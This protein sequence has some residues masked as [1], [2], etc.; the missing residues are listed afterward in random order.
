M[1][2]SS[3]PDK[4]EPNLEANELVSLACE[5]DELFR[6]QQESTALNKADRELSQEEQEQLEF[7]KRA[8]RLLRRARN[9]LNSSIDVGP[10]GSSTS[11]TGPQG[12]LT[13]TGNSTVT[14]G[15]SS[16]GAGQNPTFQMLG[17]FEVQNEI[18]QGGFSRVFRARDPQLDRLVALKVPKPGVLVDQTTR[19]RFE[20]EAHAAAILSHPNIVPT[21]EVGSAGP[22]S[23][24]AMGYCEGKTLAT[25]MADRKLDARESAE[26]ISTLAMAVEHAHQRGIVHRDLKPSNVLI[27]KSPSR[28]STDGN[29]LALSDRLRISDFGLAKFESQDAT[30]T[31]EGAIVGTPAYMSPEQ[32][33]GKV[34]GA[35]T[36]IYALGMILCELLTG[37]LP[38]L[39][40][41][42]LATLRAVE[43]YPVPNI[44]KLNPQIPKDLAAIAE[45]CL[46]KNPNERYGSAFELAEE[47]QNWLNGRPVVA[48][49]I[50]PVEQFSK[51]CRRNPAVAASLTA[52]MACLTIGLG[53]A[54]WN[55][56][57][58]EE[59]RND[60]LLFSD[61][62]VNDVL[63]AARPKG[64]DGG[65]GI[66]VKLVDAIKVAEGK[67]GESFAGRPN[68]EATA[69]NAIGATWRMLGDFERAAGQFESASTSDS[70]T[71][72]DQAVLAKIEQAS[73]LY[74]Q[75]T[76]DEALRQLDEAHQEAVRLLGDDH[77]LSIGCLNN[78]AAM[79][80][81]IGRYN[82]AIPVF[83]SL[84]EHYEPGSDEAVTIQKNLAVAYR[85]YQPERAIEILR[86]QLDLL[87]NSRGEDD[88]QTI[89]TMAELGDTY[90]QIHRGPEAREL[91]ER[92]LEL[93]TVAMGADHPKTLRCMSYLATALERCNK[94][95][96]ALEAH[97][98][99]ARAATERLSLI[100]I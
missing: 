64:K 72:P 36:D 84:L 49:S 46:R 40:D 9:N 74:R 51:W 24:I 18:G 88:Y 30:L 81:N 98:N 19:K 77:E 33:A 7:A 56:H 86:S 57:K 79:L 34:V 99:A 59:A 78:R 62:L 97:Q 70:Q 38:F 90:S 83:E 52:A 73:V 54:G 14:P 68:A 5:M 39:C 87:V 26:V 43:S 55:W 53:I 37:R 28:E 95:K 12:E 10:E 6:N 35:P 32:A 4:A 71:A 8:L 41:S 63:A 29:S 76:F 23:F 66:D 82:E 42:H 45:K 17:R 44:R 2:P 75:G 69:R 85:R 100:H 93:S 16:E 80:T 47:L 67:I 94:P 91:I 1:S 48:R 11:G 15:S 58:A 21:Y 96:A 31:Q 22:I 27:E 61:F 50:G 89:S 25:E 20:R 65:L 3:N 92:A 13:L 60:T